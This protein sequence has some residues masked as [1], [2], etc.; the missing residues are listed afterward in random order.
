MDNYV[1]KIR[2]DIKKYNNLEIQN[3]KYYEKIEGYLAVLKKKYSHTE[4]HY[5]GKWFRA[6]QSKKHN[7]QKIKQTIK[8]AQFYLYKIFENLYEII[9][10]KYDIKINIS[11]IKE[12]WS[13]RSDE[14]IQGYL[15]TINRDIEFYTDKYET[16]IESYEDMK[17]LIENKNKEKKIPKVYNYH[18][19]KK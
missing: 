11:I 9:K 6:N 14:I 13:K 3:K 10:I 19:E 8:Y 1:K 4:N 18:N 2:L 12:L 15:N 17:Y 16:Y 5:Q 7:E